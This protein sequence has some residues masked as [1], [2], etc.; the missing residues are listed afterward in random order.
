MKERLITI[1]AMPDALTLDI[2]DPADVF[3]LANDSFSAENINLNYKVVIVSATDELE[4]KTKS[5]L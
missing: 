3:T 1:V 2:T 4:V 5:E